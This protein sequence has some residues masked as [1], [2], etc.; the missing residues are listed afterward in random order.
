[1]VGSRDRPF[2][3]LF[4]KF[5]RPTPRNSRRKWSASICRSARSRM[6]S[7]ARPPRTSR[8]LT[9]FRFGD[10]D[11]IGRSSW[12]PRCGRR[13]LYSQSGRIGL[14]HAREARIPRAPVRCWVR[15]AAASKTNLDP[16]QVLFH[17]YTHHFMF[18][19]FSAAYPSWYV[20]GF[21]ETAA[22]IVMKPDGSF[23]LG[24][25]PQYRSD[26]AVLEHAERVRRTDAR[27]ARTSRPARISMAGTRSAG[28]SITI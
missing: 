13:L 23:H 3:R 2:H 5:G 14:V 27:R 17:E 26:A 28:C 9:V 15:A 18:Q 20:E 24:N 6:S 12:G 1:M 11:D 4:R 7:S 22:T 16:Q 21:A 10:T 19:H 25:P 8:K